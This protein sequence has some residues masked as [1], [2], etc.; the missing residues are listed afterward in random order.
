MID[1]DD[2]T[3]APIDGLIRLATWLDLKVEPR[4]GESPAQHRWRVARAIQREE[5]R[6]ARQPKPKGGWSW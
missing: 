6:L 1:D 3:Q 2:I 5:K 4:E